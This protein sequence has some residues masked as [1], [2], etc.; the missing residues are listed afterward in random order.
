MITFCMK[1]KL[2]KQGGGGVTFY[3]PKKWV[4]KQGL[5]P[6]DE[7]DVI[8]EDDKLIVLNE[9]MTQNKTV[10]I[11]IKGMDHTALLKTVI[12]YYEMG[13]SEITIISDN[14]MVYIPTLLKEKKITVKEEVER[15]VNRLIGF[16]LISFESNKYVLKD[17]AMT[18]PTEFDNVLRRIF[19]LLLEFQ[20]YVKETVDNK[21]KVKDYNEHHDSIAKFISFCIRLLNLSMDKTN[22]EKNN[23]HT[24]LTLLDKYTDALRW[25]LY[26]YTA[27][28]IKD[29][30]SIFA[31][32]DHFRMYYNLFYNY[33]IKLINELDRERIKLRKTLKSDE[34]VIHFSSVLEYIRAMI[35]PTI[36]LVE[37]S[38]S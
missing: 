13:Y 5:K 2:I 26:D 27:S 6:G 20:N 25:L 35:R 12:S 34:A 30:K 9:A 18:S 32:M 36:C 29:K 15:L 21:N 4:D 8:E 23:L 14:G 33:D 3:V 38:K 37:S 19:Y 24:I 17:I 28:G 11:D 22:V 1:R 16:E 7:I 10:E 31:I